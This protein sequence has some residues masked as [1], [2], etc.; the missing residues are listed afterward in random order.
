MKISDLFSRYSKISVMKKFV[1]VRRAMHEQSENF[2][3]DGKY[4]KRIKQIVELKN[5]A[6]LKIQ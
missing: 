5:I 2:S 1:D 6:A 3:R 4:F